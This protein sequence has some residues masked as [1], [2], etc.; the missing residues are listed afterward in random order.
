MSLSS[1]DA[2]VIDYGRT[3]MGRARAGMYRHTRAETLSARLIDGLLARNPALDPAEVEDVIWGCANQ[4][5]E[6]GWNMARM[7]ALL[8][9]LPHSCGAQTVNRLCGSS[10]SAL[11]TAAQA[12]M[13]GQGDVFIVGGVEHMGHLGMQHG[14]DPHPGL[15]R[16]VSRA[17]G[18]MGLTA[19]RLARLQGIS[20][21]E[22]DR[23]ALRS[24]QR[25][26]AASRAGYF[27]REILPQEGHDAN[28]FLQVFAEDETIRPDATLEGLGRLAPAF[29]PHGSVTAGNASPLA[30]GASAMLLMS[31]RRA[32]ALGLRPLA[33]I[34][35]MAVAGIEPARMGLGPIPAT[36]KALAR[37]GLTLGDIDRVELNEAFAAQALSVLQA[38]QLLER[39]DEKVNLHGGA[40]ALGHPLG[41]SGT[42]IA[43]SLLTVMAHHGGTLGMATL[44]VGMGQGMTTVFERV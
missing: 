32:R 33:R 9:R 44:C 22:Q 38:L 19:E 36:Y 30:D 7:A 21:D 17:S 39:L 29:D 31:A 42:R 43:G 25:A 28:G 35:A 13:S 1:R 11:H 26:W 34:R 40:L 2:V 27:R 8:T 14:L 4:T 18:V 12:I 5:L 41:C 20:R 6:Q 37:A 15:S 16:R 24:H 10:M 23:F 3:P